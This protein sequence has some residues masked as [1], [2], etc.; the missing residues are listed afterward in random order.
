M[1]VT[2]GFN[3]VATVTSDL[4]RLIRFYVEAFGATSPSRWRRPTTTRGW[5]SSTSAGAPR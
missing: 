1:P 3:H 2:Q 5:R 4:D